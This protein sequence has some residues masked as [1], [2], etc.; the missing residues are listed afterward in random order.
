MVRQCHCFIGGHEFYYTC[1]SLCMHIM[2]YHLVL[3]QHKVWNLLWT[4][5]SWLYSYNKLTFTVGSCIC[6]DH[7]LKHCE[8][9]LILSFPY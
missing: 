9:Q 6:I 3:A 2:Y 8:T 4:T 5:M 1:T 7:A